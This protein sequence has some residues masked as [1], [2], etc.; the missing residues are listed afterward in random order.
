[1]NSKVKIILTVSRADYVE[2]VISKIELLECDSNNTSFLCLVDGDNSL[3]IKTRNL[4]EKTKYSQ[5]LTVKVNNSGKP[6]KLNIKE[7]RKRIAYIHN[8]ARQYVN[9]ENYVFSVED[10]TLIPP[11]ALKKFL[12]HMQY[13]KSTAAI[14]GVELGRWGVP[15]VGAWK[16]D[17]VYAPNKLVSLD[18]QK[19]TD[20]VI[21]S[22]DAC[23]L[24]CILIR[25]DIYVNTEFDSRNGLGPDINMGLEARKNGYDLFINW[26]VGCRHLHTVNNKT[27]E[28]SPLEKSEQVTLSRVNDQLWK[29]IVE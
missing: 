17:D 4:V 25:A 9:D 14:T 13:A 2:K 15:Y 16:C 1:M 22:I 21:E 3:Y 23:G 8:K 11:D 27:Y 20:N 28:I 29:T 26:S 6:P 24:Y 5:R 18:N 19:I 12:F 7:R 10:D